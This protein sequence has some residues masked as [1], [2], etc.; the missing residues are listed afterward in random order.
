MQSILEYHLQNKK[1]AHGYLL[2]GEKKAALTMIAEASREIFGTDNIRQ[3]PDFFSYSFALFGIEQSRTVIDL[4]AKKSFGGT[5]KIFQL[6]FGEAT[7]EAQ[8][9]LL[10]LFEEP[11][12]NTYFFIYTPALENFIETLRS[13]LIPIFVSF[14]HSVSESDSGDEERVA[15]KFLKMNVGE[16]LDFFAKLK[17]REEAKNLILG[18][19]VE[20]RRNKPLSLKNCGQIKKIEEGLKLISQNIPLSLIGLYVLS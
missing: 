6:E 19:M 4:A 13:R 1:L 15:E 2:Y 8:N 11:A 7:R 16:K 3:N 12:A 5:A 20:L 18:V 10:K 14:G 9:A 17:D